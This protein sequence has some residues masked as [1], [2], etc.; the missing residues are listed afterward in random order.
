[1][2]SPKLLALATSLLLL[3]VAPQANATV[4]TYAPPTGLSNSGPLVSRVVFSVCD[5]D[6]TC[7]SLLAEGNIQGAEWTFAVGAWTSLCPPPQGKGTASDIICG[8]TAGY[9]WYGLA[10]DYL[11]FPGDNVNFRRAMQFLQDYSYIQGTVLGRAGGMATNTPVP[12]FAYSSAC[13]TG[14]MNSH[15]GTAQ[16]LITAGEELEETSD[17][18]KAETLY[19]DN[20]GTPCAGTYGTLSEWCTFTYCSEGGIPFAPILF[21]VGPHH[22]GLWAAAMVSW[23]AQI[24]LPID[25]HRIT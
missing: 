5:N 23:A 1:M 8:S 6:T 11:K 17:G 22:E 16:S 14:P 2:T 19:C 7:S 4:G 10:F 9:S 20:G 24:G 12:C 15:Y 13:N 21:Y 25:A 18:Q 3:A